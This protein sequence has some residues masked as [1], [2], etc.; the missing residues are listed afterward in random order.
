[1]LCKEGGSADLVPS[2]SRRRNNS[3]TSEVAVIR[4]SFNNSRTIV[5]QGTLGLS[6]A[7]LGV[8]SWMSHLLYFSLYLSI[9]IY[10]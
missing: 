6:S 3:A 9:Y 2:I 5:V 1:M 4:T 10:I 8:E 7:R